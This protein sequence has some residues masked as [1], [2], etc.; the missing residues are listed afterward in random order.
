ME[1]LSNFI[2]T[3]RVLKALVIIVLAIVGKLAEDRVFGWVNDMLDSALSNM[4][5]NVDISLG[6]ILLV[7]AILIAGIL[8][9][10]QARDSIKIIKSENQNKKLS[11]IEDTYY[12]VI[13]YDGLRI[14]Q[15]TKEAYELEY[16]KIDRTI[17][18]IWAIVKNGNRPIKDCRIVVEAVDILI[19]QN[20]DWTP[21]PTPFERKSLKWSV[22]QV[23]TNGTIEMY[24]NTEARVEIAV[25]VR[26]PNPAIL[27]HYLDLERNDKRENRLS[28]R[29]KIRVRLEAKTTSNNFDKFIKPIRYEIEFTWRTDLLLKLEGINLYEQ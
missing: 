21:S 2:K 27:I 12:D 16:V 8:L 18:N 6:N 15:D 14:V 20:T 7:V 3:R 23:E 17:V 28:G 1:K 26:F 9:A 5:I 29:Y 19:S 11:S 24:P 10:L 22:G 13:E 25:A 4:N